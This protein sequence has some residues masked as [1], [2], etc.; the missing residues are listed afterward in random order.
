ML[1]YCSKFGILFTVL[2]FQFQDVKFDQTFCQFPSYE[3]FS[4]LN[5]FIIFALEL[6][7]KI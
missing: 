4:V 1:K 3:K 7:D 2:I 6:F 5:Q